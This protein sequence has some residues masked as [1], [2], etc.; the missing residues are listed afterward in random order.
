[1]K[2]WD[3]NTHFWGGG[4]DS[5]IFIFGFI[6]SLYFEFWV[7]SFFGQIPFIFLENYSHTPCFYF[8]VQSEIGADEFQEIGMTIKGIRFSFQI[9]FQN[10]N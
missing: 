1:M 9:E 3:S 2:E 5:S 7:N 6:D 10:V 8:H 4:N